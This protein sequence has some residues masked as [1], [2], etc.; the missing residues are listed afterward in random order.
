[1]LRSHASGSVKALQL[2]VKRKA[3]VLEQRRL[4]SFA[5]A[6][7]RFL[8]KRMAESLVRSSIECILSVDVA[9]FDETP[10]PLRAAHADFSSSTTVAV[11]QAAMKVS[12]GTSVAKVFSTDSSFAFLLG[13]RR[14]GEVE[15][16]FVIVVGTSVN[17]LQNIA[18][19]SENCILPGVDGDGR[20][21][22]CRERLHVEDSTDHHSSAYF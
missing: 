5:W 7:D 8:R 22:P 6:M 20:V 12:K 11:N 16:E 19:N 14:D 15:S 13:H 3:L 17:H 10:L 18:Q 4:A 21:H 1:M 2:D 9:A